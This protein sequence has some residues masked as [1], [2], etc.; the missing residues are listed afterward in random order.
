MVA[1]IPLLILFLV[2][3]TRHKTGHEHKGDFGLVVVILVI[4]LLILRPQI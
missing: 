3:G 4:A 1:W 2:L